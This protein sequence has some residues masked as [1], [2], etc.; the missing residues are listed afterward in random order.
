MET[1]EMKL[2]KN[3]CSLVFSKR[4]LTLKVVVGTADGNCCAV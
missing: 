3:T 2:P 1:G 4:K